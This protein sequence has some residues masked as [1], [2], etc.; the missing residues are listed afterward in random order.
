[1]VVS[2]LNGVVEQA[3]SGP[4]SLSFVIDANTTVEDLAGRTAT[5]VTGT[6]APITYTVQGNVPW[7]SA[8][9]NT[10]AVDGNLGL[11]LVAKPTGLNCRSASAPA[12]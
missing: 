10:T 9:G 3:L 11:A 6:A 12:H 1:M 2:A 8:T 5:I 4:P 7:L